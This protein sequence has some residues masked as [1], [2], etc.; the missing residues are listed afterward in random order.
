MAFGFH[1]T[2]LCFV[3]SHLAAHQEHVEMRNQNYHEIV[4][5][6]HLGN[7]AFDITNHFGHVF[8]T[9]DLNYRIDVER[10]KCCELIEKK[11]WA[12]LRAADQL[13]NQRDK[14]GKTFRGWTEGVVAF[15]PTYRYTRG[16]KTYND[17]VRPLELAQLTDTVGGCR[18]RVSPRGAIA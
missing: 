13:I 18:K 17:E 2:T 9:G 12:A 16:T 10:S 15:P 7:S 6:L 4:E 3:N 11:D 1:E 8:W 14:L 5:E